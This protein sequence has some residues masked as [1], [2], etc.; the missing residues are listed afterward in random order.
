[1]ILRRLGR[2]EGTPL[3]AHHMAVLRS[4]WHLVTLFGVGWA[5]LFLWLGWSGAR[6]ADVSIL[7]GVLAATFLAAAVYWLLG[8]RGR[9]LAWVVLAVMATLAWLAGAA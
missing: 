1:M 2:G 9:H 4:T 8:T 5:A 6:S 7:A 3:S